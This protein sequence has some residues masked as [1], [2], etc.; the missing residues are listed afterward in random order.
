MSIKYKSSL[1]VVALLIVCCIG[2]VFMYYLY[3]KNSDNTYQVVQSENLSINFLGNNNISVKNENKE[4]KFSITNNSEKDI[5]YTINAEDIKNFDENVKLVLICGNNTF[6]ID[7]T[8]NSE[9]ILL[10]NNKIGP[11]ET[12]NFVLKVSNESENNFSFDILVNEVANSVETFAKTILK[13]NELKQ[14]VTSVANDVSISDEGLISNT[15]ENG[16]TYYF[17]GNVVNN[18]VSFADMT[19]RIIR[20]NGDGTVRLILNE[21]LSSVQNYTSNSENYHYDG[22]DIKSFLDEWYILYL[23]NYD[24]YIANGKFCDDTNI[25]DGKEHYNSYTRVF[26]D[27][28]PNFSCLGDKI[29]SK[30]GLLTI[31]EVIYAGGNIK[32]ANESFYLYNKDSSSFWT[33]SAARYKNGVYY[34]FIITENGKVSYETNATLNRGVRPV[35]NLNSEVVVVGDGTI[36]KPY[37]L[38]DVN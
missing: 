15:D 30:I 31:D 20:I 9:K 35:I 12:V 24:S 3:D 26:I 23:N 28:I 16:A 32:D 27:K 1:S 38:K 11:L 34:P 13:Q 17:R 22:S 6:N 2:L 33:M 8:D 5:I 29:T 14:P 10:D 37:M 21:N 18:Y 19:W 25:V 4:L 36:N 7:S